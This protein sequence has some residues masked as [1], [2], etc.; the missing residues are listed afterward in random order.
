MATR[1]PLDRE[2]GRIYVIADAETNVIDYER[3]LG[4]N[5]LVH[6]IYDDI[7]YSSLPL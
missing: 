5:N 4:R 7:N 1:G 3:V 2:A 6:H